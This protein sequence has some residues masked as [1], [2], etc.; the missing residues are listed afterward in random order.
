MAV[1]MVYETSDSKPVKRAY[2]YRTPRKKGYPTRLSTLAQVSRW[3]QRQQPI[4]SN[5]S[6]A[7]PLLSALFTVSPS[8]IRHSSISSLQVIRF[9]KLSNW[10]V[11]GTLKNSTNRFKYGGDYGHF[12]LPGDIIALSFVHMNNQEHREQANA[13]NLAWM[14]FFAVTKIIGFITSMVAL[15]EKLERI[16]FEANY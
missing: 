11:K 4:N 8:G 15:N 9:K 6:P 7:P 2:F 3:F 1:Q 5:E 14:A 13:A 16:P 12:G 10:H